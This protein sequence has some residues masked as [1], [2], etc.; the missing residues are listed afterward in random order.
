MPCLVTFTKPVWEVRYPTI[1]R[2]L[3]SE[4]ADIIMLG[5]EEL[6]TIDK[7]AIGLKG[8][9]TRVKKTFVPSR[10]KECLF[11]HQ[12][13][14]EASAMQLLVLL[15]NSGKLGSEDETE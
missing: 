13:N 9:P 10:K 1:P 14:D 6:A 4:K 15:K 12:E 3:A 8:S 5:E 2:K 7:T 11:I